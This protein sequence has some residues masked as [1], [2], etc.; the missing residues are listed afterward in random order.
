M[1]PLNRT[2]LFRTQRTV[3]TVRGPNGTGSRTGPL[4]KGYYFLLELNV[5]LQS[6][7][8]VE[9]SMCSP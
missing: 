2:H 4:V 8:V 1:S 5:F 3:G 9:N 7:D 6:G